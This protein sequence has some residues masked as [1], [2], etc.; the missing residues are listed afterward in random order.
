VSVRSELASTAVANFAG[1]VSVRSELA[2]TAVANEE[3]AL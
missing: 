3:S 2:S 1:A